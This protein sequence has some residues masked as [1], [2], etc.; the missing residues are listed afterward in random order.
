MNHTKVEG[1]EGD[2]IQKRKDKMGRFGRN[3]ERYREQDKLSQAAL[4][5]MVGVERST[6]NNIETGRRWPGPDLV[7][8]LAEALG[9]S[10]ANLWKEV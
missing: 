2:W 9:V 8:K 3:L 5:K 7:A 10:I 6:I 1:L 4:A